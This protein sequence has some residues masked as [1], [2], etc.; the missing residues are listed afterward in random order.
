MSSQLQELAD[1]N[2]AIKKN[3]KP[4][5]LNCKQC[6]VS[7]LF[8]VCKTSCND[9]QLHACQTWNPSKRQL[10]GVF[11]LLHRAVLAPAIPSS[12]NINILSSLLLHNLHPPN[13]HQPSHHAGH[14]RDRPREARSG[15]IRPSVLH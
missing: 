5:C 15:P 12:F 1:K 10:I 11:Q 4:A 8:M 9:G 6:I 13:P 7:S 2:E 14:A 3:R